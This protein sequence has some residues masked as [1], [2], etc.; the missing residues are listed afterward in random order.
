PGPAGWIVLLWRLLVRLLEWLGP[1]DHPHMIAIIQ[2]PAEMYCTRCGTVR[3]ARYC[4][5]C[6]ADVDRQY[7]KLVRQLARYVVDGTADQRHRLEAALAA[8][9]ERQV[10]QLRETHQKLLTE[11]LER[12]E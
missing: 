4:P 9:I 8:E 2:A 5:V 12:L 3:V 1:P 11:R 10:A 7:R 6:G